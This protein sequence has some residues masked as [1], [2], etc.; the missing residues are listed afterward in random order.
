[1][2]SE[3]VIGSGALPGPEA[4]AA[5][6]ATNVIPAWHALDRL[7]LRLIARGLAG[8]PM[9]LALW[10]GTVH[11]VTSD[12]PIATV[13]ILDRATLLR[14]V[15]SPDL[16]FGEGYM[17]GTLVVEGD[18]VRFLEAVSRHFV[19]RSLG[20]C[21]RFRRAAK[22]TGN[23]LA[24]AQRNA[25]HHYDLGNEFYQQ[26]LDPELV[27]T[28][29]YFPSP[30]M[31]LE[32][33][34]VA[35]LDYVAR[36]LRLR[37]GETVFEAGCGWGALALHMAR[38]YGVRVRAWNVSRE[39]IAW[40]R[41]RA[42]RERLDDRVEFIERDYR[43]IAGTCDAFVSVG[44]LEHVGRAHY[45]ALAGV[46]DRCLHPDH[47]R[48]LLHFIGRNAPAP[49][50]PWIGRHIFPG[51]YLPSLGEVV[52]SV[53]ERLGLSVIDTE[54]LRLHYARTIACWLDRFE[55][56]VSEIGA[57]Y[58]DGFV[59]M[60]RLYLAEAQAGF[61]SG[62]LQLFQITF[63]RALNNDVSLTRDDL[64]RKEW[65]LRSGLA[66]EAGSRG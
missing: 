26:W 30:E 50:A 18:L 19:C 1:M 63:A 57:R 40:A 7:C 35:K 42:V 31:P 33:A 29:A 60:W 9:C 37:P 51:A 23:G 46:I 36:K 27:Y 22:W 34:Q 54:N 28:C 17:D 58:G 38:H 13:R 14:L 15:V 64:Y 44:M 2:P 32:E 21:S 16:G 6:D 62:N 41:A 4:S 49:L 5:H 3:Q 56:A 65:G 12:P 20:P 48:G 39:Q 8:V 43:D 11:A 61:L 24:R 25:R 55:R 53:L 10:D 45:P 52:S 66:D 59:R 47:G